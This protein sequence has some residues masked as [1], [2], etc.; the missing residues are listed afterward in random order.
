MKGLKQLS[1]MIKLCIKK[2]INNSELLFY[3]QPDGTLKEN[4]L[5]NELLRVHRATEG[6][7]IRNKNEI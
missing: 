4:E 6:K 2:R 7:K 1:E 3:L 5:G